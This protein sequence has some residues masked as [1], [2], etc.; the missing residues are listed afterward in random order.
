M[1]T[2]IPLDA[3]HIALMHRW[4]SHGEAFRWYGRQ[5]T[6]EESVRQKYLVAKPQE[7]TRCFIVQHDQEPVAFLQYYR[8]SDHPRYASL[9]GAEPHDYGMDLF[10]GRDDQ[11]GRGIGT[12]IVAAALKELI[13]AQADAKR[14]L[15]GPSPENQ[16]AIRCY[17]KCGFRY[18]K[19]VLTND[20]E[21]EYIMVVE[22]PNASPT[23][24]SGKSG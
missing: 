10:I 15:V 4:L 16:R 13:F 19:T 23:R 12:Q 14:C 21:P 9:V 24:A 2:F 6:T 18:V 11:I 17:E 22:T 5:P 3:S 1:I 7:G 8:I 20:T